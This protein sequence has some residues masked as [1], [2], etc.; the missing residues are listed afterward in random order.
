MSPRDTIVA[1]V[2]TNST[3]KF[4]LSAIERKFAAALCGTLSVLAVLCFHHSDAAGPTAI[5]SIT[6][7]WAALVGAHAY[8][9]AK[10]FKPD[11]DEQKKV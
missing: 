5:V 1:D 6:S 10:G 8:A 2:D 4:S 3:M 11:P 7:L 9:E